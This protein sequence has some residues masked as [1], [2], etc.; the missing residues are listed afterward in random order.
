M[1][2]FFLGF[3]LLLTLGA[4]GASVDFPADTPFFAKPDIYSKIIK[5]SSEAASYPVLEEAKMYYSN[6][7]PLARYNH[8]YKVQLPEGEAYASGELG[9]AKVKGTAEPV[10][11]NKIEF[12][13]W[14]SYL[15]NAFGIGLVAVLYCF[16]RLRKNGKI[17]A[18]SVTEAAFLVAIAVL[19]REFLLAQ[20]VIGL[21]NTITSM[22]D[23]YGY[24]QPAVGLLNGTLDGKW[25]MTCGLGIW[26]MPFILWVKAKEFY[27]IAIAFDYF[28]GF[29][30]GPSLL[31]LGFLILRKLAF[32]N[33]QA[34]AAIAIWAVLPFFY[35]HVESW[36]LNIFKSFFAAI[37]D[38]VDWW[39]SYSILIHTGFTSMSDVPSTFLI[40][41]IIYLLLIMPV[42]RGYA[43]LI[44]VLFAFACLVRIND[45]LMAP[46]FVY[47]AFV[48]YQDKLKDW[49]YTISLLLLAAGSFAAGFAI[50]LAINFH[51]FGNPLTFGYVLHYTD[52]A[53]GMRPSNGFTWGT[54]FKAVHIKF[55]SNANHAIWSMGLT[56]LLL[57][58]NV[59]NRTIFAIWI[60]PLIWFFLG[61]SHT[62]CDA[63]RFIMP[64][65]L[66][67]FAAFC[68][69]GIWGELTKKKLLAL[70]TLLVAALIFT[71]P[72]SYFIK[73]LPF[74]WQSTDYAAM[75][76]HLNWI[77]PAILLAAAWWIKVKNAV[78]LVIVFIVVFY[79]A[80]PY[81]H[82]L[83]LLLVL[84]RALWDCFCEI[85]TV[86]FK[87]KP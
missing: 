69:L 86:F 9:A 54:F 15:Y 87:K 46:L 79:L 62:F 76:W 1:K 73:Q 39:R 53:E 10:V 12:H 74:D 55:L 47:L 24:F 66:P 35:F 27:D 16:V 33:W 50:Q 84:L 63:R 25:T 5:V 51:Q 70:S 61:Y 6:K 81:T 14:R 13:A 8:F 57:M 59:R 64:T 21:E 49:K 71:A 36:E 48:K 41:L 75:L 17:V 58:K 77:M 19:T 22:A 11:Y 34:F 68:C 82:M 18:N 40:F 31:V 2:T 45:I 80:N 23:E 38:P 3:L 67:M 83:L 72:S 78:I 65:Y 42:K 60:V 30:L 37:P 7:H 26:Y 4:A 44:G 52:W 43:V 29:V 32:N 20:V 28:S 85:K 56:G